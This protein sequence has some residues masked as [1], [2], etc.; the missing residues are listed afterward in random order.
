MSAP[1]P[2]PVRPVTGR[3]VAVGDTVQQRGTL[4][5]GELV[6]WDTS[7]RLITVRI[8]GAEPEQY[9]AFGFNLTW[10]DHE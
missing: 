1:Q 6:G 10:S 5:K 7:R 9:A 4:R 3:P 8:G 2:I